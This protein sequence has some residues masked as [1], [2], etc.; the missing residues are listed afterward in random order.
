MH[1][2]E[3]SIPS[4]FIS[5]AKNVEELNTATTLQ[6]FYNIRAG[7]FEDA[8]NDIPHVGI[9]YLPAM[10]RQTSGKLY[11]CWGGHNFDGPE[12]SHIW[13]EPDLSAPGSAG[14]WKI[15]TARPYTTTE[16]MFD[17][18][19]SWAAAHVSG[20]LLATGRFR[21]GGQ[22]GMG[23]SVIAID[24]WDYGN[25]PAP[26][27]EIG[28]TP[29]LL[30]S[31]T[32]PGDPSEFKMNGYGGADDWKGAAWLTA[33]EKAAVVFIGTKGVGRHWY[34]TPERECHEACGDLQGWWADR[35]EGQ[36]IFYNPDDLAAVADG[37][38]QPYEP[39][40]YATMEVDRFLYRTLGRQTKEHLGGA[41]FDRER[42]YLYIFE[43]FGDGDKPLVHVF[44]VSG[45]GG[46][47]S[48]QGAVTGQKTVTQQPPSKP[49]QA[50]GA[51]ADVPKTAHPGTP[52]VLAPILSLPVWFMLRRSR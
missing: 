36:I 21:Q 47:G 14:P 27:T 13:R 29:L 26:Y 25:P 48:G 49:A 38:M 30:Y 19:G 5:P 9:A 44:T 35:F 23:P 24:P 1:V 33:G 41:A 52:L 7:L 3:I 6:P 18:P 20:R 4:P 45:A 17:I 32:N 15:S 50:P 8:M 28:G 2:S 40:P 11:S 51:G 31:S 39:Q 43:M 46:T 37:R 16:Y 42:G 34:G 10:G 12:Y 22:G